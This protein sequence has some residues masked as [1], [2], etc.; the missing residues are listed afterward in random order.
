MPPRYDY[1]I[2]GAGSA[3][4]VVANRLSASG[5]H[6]VLLL[7][8]G[9]SDS[10]PWIYIPIGYAK[11]LHDDKVNWRYRTAPDPGI[12]NRR[13]YWPTSLNCSE[14]CQSFQKRTRSSQGPRG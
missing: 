11:T 3:G 9:G 1:L 12:N 2:V 6:D 10:S 7:E 14:S 5:K 8:V 13:S 4:C